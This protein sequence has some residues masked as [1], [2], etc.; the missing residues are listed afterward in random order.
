MTWLVV[1]RLVAVRLVV[2]RLVAVRLVVGMVTA[3]AGPCWNRRVTAR[4]VPAAWW[5]R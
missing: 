4:T 2:R 3:P 5:C 1:V